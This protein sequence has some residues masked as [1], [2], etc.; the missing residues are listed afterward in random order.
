MGEA[1]AFCLFHLSQ[2]SPDKRI[3]AAPR[4]A[5]RQARHRQEL[6]KKS[7]RWR[8][9]ERFPFSENRNAD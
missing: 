7:G 9:A 4:S 1:F 8:F 5:L 6:R 2:R 3:G